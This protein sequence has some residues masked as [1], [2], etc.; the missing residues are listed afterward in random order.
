[1]AKQ[2]SPT[3]EQR[4]IA[5]QLGIKPEDLAERVALNSADATK[6]VKDGGPYQVTCVNRT[7]GLVS[8]H[9]TDANE[10]SPDPNELLQ[11]LA[12]KVDAARGHVGLQLEAAARD[13][14]AAAQR[15]L[16]IV[17]GRKQA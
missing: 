6:A 14:A 15:L 5:W 2:T 1:M 16:E 17:I 3:Q 13:I 9:Q 11:V 8:L 12:R 10:R 4:D 7:T